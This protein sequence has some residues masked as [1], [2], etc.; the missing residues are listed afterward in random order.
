MW[1]PFD[2][3]FSLS[4]IHFHGP[5]HLKT[6]KTHDSLFIF[7]QVSL[8]SS[9]IS[10]RK[11]SSHYNLLYLDY[12]HTYNPNIPHFQVSCSW[13]R[14]NHK[15]WHVSI[16]KSTWDQCKIWGPRLSILD[17]RFYH[18]PERNNDQVG[19]WKDTCDGAVG[20]L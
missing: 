11:L 8:T 4:S 17:E 13:K 1:L 6:Q 3:A 12:I 2:D 14:N 15:R 16:L 10:Q 7:F 18:R 5:I 9:V 19:W 20:I